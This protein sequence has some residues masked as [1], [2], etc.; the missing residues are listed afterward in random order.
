MPN[1]SF[2]YKTDISRYRYYYQRLQT[3]SQKPITQVSSALLF[4]IGA[5]IFFAVVA[6]KPTLETVAELT[7]KINDQKKILAQ[8]EKK[9]AALATVQQQY[10]FIQPYL[11][12]LDEA[13]P[14]SYAT[15][16]LLHD[17]EAVASNLGIPLSNIKISNIEFPPPVTD[18][19][20]LK[21]LNFSI[22]L[23]SFYPTAK[24]FMQSLEQLPRLIVIDS[25]SMSTNEGNRSSA[26][27]IPGQVQ[28]T[29]QCKS[30]YRIN[31]MV[32]AP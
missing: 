27:A 18:Q 1:P 11:P 14:T 3:L 32:V 6:I 24:M 19:D 30:F 10:E 20:Q 4:T 21:D 31:D 12:A 13:V 26:L 29:I 5:I 16:Q 25:V 15:Q 23:T 8:A 7:K 9:V 17:I 2:N 28:M 22:S